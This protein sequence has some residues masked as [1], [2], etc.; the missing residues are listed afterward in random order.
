[1]AT[2]ELTAPHALATLPC[3]LAGRCGGCPEH[4]QSLEQQRSDKRA[5][6]AALMHANGIELPEQARLETPAALAFRE[7][8][9]LR[10]EGERL[11]LIGSESPSG[12]KVVIDMASCPLAVPALNAWLA[13]LRRHPLPVARAS[14]RLRVAATGLR[15]LWIDCAH[16]DVKALLDHP[17]YL[18]TLLGLTPTPVVELGPKAR[19]VALRDGRPALVE[20]TLEP[21]SQTFLGGEPAPL[22]TLVRAFSQPGAL[23]NRA[24]VDAVTHAVLDTYA[25]RV[26]ELGAGAGN[27]TLPLLAAGVFVRAVELDG[28]ALARSADQAGLSTKLEVHAASFE[29]AE[30]IAVLVQGIDAVLADPPRQGLGRFIE[31]LARLSRGMRPA[32]LVYVSCHPEALAKDGA[33]LAALGYRL[34]AL[35]GVDQF[36]W[37][38]HAE[39]IATFTRA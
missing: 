15:G 9:D 24:L 33:G 10:W 25:K 22:Y 26:L 36:P 5:R 4:A 3:A 7:H 38:A 16:S 21:W 31:A 13:E 32:Q 19:R 17:S 34:A 11:G 23:P 14:L 2:T 20:P 39:W 18:P 8:L 29:R 1:M 6:L 12:P 28:A 35:T 30:D 37:T 27:L